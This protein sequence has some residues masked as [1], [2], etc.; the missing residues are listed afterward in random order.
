MKLDIAETIS[1]KLITTKNKNNEITE[2][3]KK[4]VRYGVYI[5]YV[6]VTKIGSLLIV[7]YFL[8]IFSEVL[9]IWILFGILRS[10]AFGIH[11][12]KSIYCTIATFVIFIGGALVSTQFVLEDMILNIIYFLSFIGLLMYAPAD[13]K[14]RPLVGKEFRKK[15]KIKTII[16]FMTILAIILALNIY[17][18][19]I[20]FSISAMAETISVLPITYKIFRRRYNNYEYKVSSKS[21]K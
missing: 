13:T 9:T 17:H 20:L 19:K 3:E 8:N 10:S 1:N 7:A 21:N 6:N 16:S 5:L 11:S 18:L 2:L 12:S 14:A 15:L 4:K